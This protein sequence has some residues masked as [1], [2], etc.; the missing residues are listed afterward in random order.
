MLIQFLLL[1]V[2]MGLDFVLSIPL[3]VSVQ[4]FFGLAATSIL[5]LSSFFSA[6]PFIPWGTFFIVFSVCLTLIVFMF[7]SKWV[8]MAFS[9]IMSI[10]RK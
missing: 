4:D 10:I 6:F 2:Y 8:L 5:E 3:P 1:L 7:V 9:A